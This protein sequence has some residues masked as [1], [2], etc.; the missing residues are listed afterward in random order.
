M[1]GPEFRHNQLLE[2]LGLSRGDSANVGMEVKW[3]KLVGGSTIEFESG[4]VTAIAGANNCGKSTLLSQL[5]SKLLHPDHYPSP[6]LISEVEAE[7]LG[8]HHDFLDWLCKNAALTNEEY[9]LSRSVFQRLGMR[10]PLESFQEW[11]RNGPD[12]MSSGVPA[13]FFVKQMGAGERDVSSTHRKPNVL[14]APTHPIHHLIESAELMDELNQ[15]TMRILGKELSLDDLNQE[16]QLR[17]GVPDVAYPNGREDPAEYQ[18]AVDALPT[19]VSQGD[20]MRSLLGILIPLV[21]ATY[22]IFIVDE[23]EAFLHPPQAFALGQE[24]GRIAAEK[25]VQVI[26][27]THDRNLLAGLLNSSSPLSVVRLVRTEDSTVAHQLKSEELK[28]IWD[29]PVLKYSNVLDGLFHELVVLA[30]NERDCRFY[31]AALDARTPEADPGS[32]HT[33]TI[34]ATDVL[35]V[36]TS[37]TGGMPKVA[38]ALRALQVPVI[39]CPDLDVLDNESVLKNIVESLGCTWEG[40]HDDWATVAGPLN[41][42]GPAR[43]V[44]EVHQAVGEEFKRILAEDAMALYDSVNR[45]RIKEALGVASRP[46]DEVKNYGVDGLMRKCRD[47]EAVTRLVEGLAERQ[48]VVVQEGELESFGYSLGVDKG[49]EWLPAALRK[50][51]QASAEVQAHISRLMR[52]AEP[53]IHPGPS[54]V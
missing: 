25:S 35:F 36:P 3:I 37:G 18:L 24:L 20:G 42:A 23:P 48:V 44:A 6:N 11:T 32:A 30:E 13:Q 53:M 33:S 31:E 46:W 7:T 2:N 41:S 22:P 28:R 45:R 5:G 52:A 54:R 12:S 47:P 16:Q 15:L 49:K 26:L 40:L 38:K 39:A 1:T 29:D 17:V 21:T 9:S 10:V 34:P 50:N 19:L 43:L 4:G 27:A 14:E 51:L 8:N